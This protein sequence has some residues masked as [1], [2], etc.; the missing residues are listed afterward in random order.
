MKYY[1]FSITF[2]S[3][4]LIG[5]PKL[6]QL[7]AAAGPWY[8]QCAWVH[9]AWTWLV[10]QRVVVK[11]WH[12]LSVEDLVEIPPSGHV[13]PGSRPMA[14]CY[15]GKCT[16][17]PWRKRLRRHVVAGCR[18]DGDVWRDVFDALRV[19]PIGP[20]WRRYLVLSFRG[21]Q[22]FDQ[23]LQP[24][25]PPSKPLLHAIVEHRSYLLWL[26]GGNTAIKTPRTVGIYGPQYCNYWLDYHETWQK[27]SRV[28]IS[29][30][31][32]FHKNTINFT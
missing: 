6:P 2:K 22:R 32:N 16:T 7:L 30:L 11:V 3:E 27:W 25:Y 24:L 26:S 8:S 14:V 23:W 15:Y 28:S 5:N 9:R 4:F 12:S 19:H 1:W 21:Y 18:Q 13:C 17:T 20:T 29:R 31:G 10:L